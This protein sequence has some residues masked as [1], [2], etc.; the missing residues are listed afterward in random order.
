[1]FRINDILK[2][3]VGTN[4]V[5]ANALYA[6]LVLVNAL[7]ANGVRVRVLFRQKLS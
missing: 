6:S 2:K 3:A 5:G 4:V 1:M 7:R